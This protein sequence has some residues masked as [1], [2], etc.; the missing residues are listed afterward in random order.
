MRAPE[1]CCRMLCDVSLA[2]AT[3]QKRAISLS[4][5]AQGIVA[6]RSIFVFFVSFVVHF[7]TEVTVVRSNEDMR[8]V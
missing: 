7:Y 3:G 8:E 6:L 4:L 1:K 5:I 2:L